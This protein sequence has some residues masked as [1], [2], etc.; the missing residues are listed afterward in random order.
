MCVSAR[1]IR[2]HLEQS[3]STFHILLQIAEVVKAD[4]RPSPPA[5]CH[6]P[7]VHH[8]NVLKWM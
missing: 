2:N 6:L 4:Q 7:D 1:K 5:K 8:L 3:V